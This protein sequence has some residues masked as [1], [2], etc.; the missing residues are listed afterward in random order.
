[1]SGLGVS[2]RVP[3]DV[4]AVYLELNFLTEPRHQRSRCLVLGV[5]QG[6]PEVMRPEFMRRPCTVFDSH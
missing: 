2:F 5:R 6:E 1:M 4:V 3:L